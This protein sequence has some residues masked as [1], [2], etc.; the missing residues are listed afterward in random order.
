MSVSGGT[1]ELNYKWTFTLT[2]DNFRSIDNV[3]KNIF[4]VFCH[5]FGQSCLLSACH[6]DRSM[7]NG[8]TT[9]FFSIKF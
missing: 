1:I 7:P 5:E 3:V 2:P 6:T 4:C 9:G 8:A